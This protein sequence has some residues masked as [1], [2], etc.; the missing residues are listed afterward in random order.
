MVMLSLLM[1]LAEL[2]EQSAALLTPAANGAAKVLL[3]LP[4]QVGSSCTCVPP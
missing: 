1:L 4:V 2:R 3:R